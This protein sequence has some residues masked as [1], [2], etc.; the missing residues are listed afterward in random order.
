MSNSV[1]IQS[2]IRH[3]KSAIPRALL[4]AALYVAFAVYLCRPHWAGLTGWRWLLPVNSCLAAV[5]VYVLSRRWVAGFT[6]SLLA[7]VVYGFGPFLLGLGKFHA[8]AGLLA[9]CV[10]WLF[11]PA[12]VVRAARPRF[13]GK[14]PS[15]RG[16]WLGLP[17][18]L[19]PFLVIV[20]FFYLS[21]GRRLFA[22][23][24]QVDTRWS[25]L[26]GFIAPLALIDRSTAL[27]GLYHVPVA[28]LVLGLAMMGKAR[29]YGI[30]LVL[31]AGLLL[32]F[33]KLLLGPE[34]VA[35]LG[36]SPMLWLSI[37]MTWCAVLSGI[38][39]QGLIEAGP[40]DRKWVLAAAITLGVLAIVA[41]LLAARCFQVML[42]L[43]DGYGRLFVQA[44]ELY[45][46][47]AV[48]VAVIF[49]LAQH[50][51]RLHWLRW[52]VLCA[53]LG[54]DIFLGARYIADAIL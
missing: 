4:A 20:L 10:P 30:L 50:N 39:M 27:L 37:P 24:L 9:A 44:A 21:A 42:G 23:P 29:R 46:L 17:L 25:D 19:V 43:G 40:A 31:P 34:R 16:K 48:A 11:V 54:V 38:G 12:A 32:A 7:G 35:W 47:G 15:T 45:L 18:L 2:A 1:S 49:F 14:K 26:A 13:Q 22:A 41:L 6:G 52:A 28:A 8:S 36:V 5:G 3:P 51:F 53:A 33:S